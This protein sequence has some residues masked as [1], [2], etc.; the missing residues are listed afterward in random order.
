MLFIYKG[1][2]ICIFI[3][4]SYTT[5]QIKTE[6]LTSHSS[7][8]MYVFV[9]IIKHLQKLMQGKLLKCLGP[10]EFMPN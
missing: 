3:K 4:L 8:L 7:L 1:Q 2:R 5:M 10:L 6:K 9:K